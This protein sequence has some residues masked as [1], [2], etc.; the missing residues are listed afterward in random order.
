MSKLLSSLAVLV[1]ALAGCAS[2]PTMLRVAEAPGGLGAAPGPADWSY[3]GGAAVI[4][5]PG[6]LAFP[7]ALAIKIDLRR[8]VDERDLVEAIAAGAIAVAADAPCRLTRVAECDGAACVGE[9]ELLGPGVCVL[10]LRAATPSGQEFSGCWHHAEI[11]GDLDD[12]ALADALA[13]DVDAA[14]TAC[15]EAS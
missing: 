14:L 2:E 10:R 1:A 5:P 4:R 9:I 7:R 13:A 15:E 8:A 3:S 12:G 11:E 6:T